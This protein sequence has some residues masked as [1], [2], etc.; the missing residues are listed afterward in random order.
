MNQPMAPC[1]PPS[2]NSS[3]SQGISRASIRRVTMKASSGRK[4]TTPISRPHSRWIYSGQ[5]SALKPGRSMP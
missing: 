5:N 3:N 4:N 1:S 2:T